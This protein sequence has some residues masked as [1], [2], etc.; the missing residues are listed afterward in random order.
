MIGVVKISL[1][2]QIDYDHHTPV[3]VELCNVFVVGFFLK[4]LNFSL[5][6][7]SVAQ[8]SKPLDLRDPR[9]FAPWLVPSGTTEHIEH[10]SSKP[11]GKGV[12]L[13]Y[14]SC[15][16]AKKIFDYIYVIAYN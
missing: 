1:C 4:S 8:R 15:S 12:S 10:L 7:N 2:M 9:D 6:V 13:N 5:N 14:L 11:E 3:L 16:T